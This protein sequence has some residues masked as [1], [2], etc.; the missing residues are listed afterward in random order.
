[1]RSI[2]AYTVV[3]RSCGQRV[4]AVPGDVGDLGGIRN[5]DVDVTASGAPR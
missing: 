4:S 1:M 2:A 5:A 3:V